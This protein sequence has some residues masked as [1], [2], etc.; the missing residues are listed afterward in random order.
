MGKRDK[1]SSIQ[2]TQNGKERLKKKKKPGE[3]FEELIRRK[4]RL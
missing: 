2:F 3:S 1:Y 4:F